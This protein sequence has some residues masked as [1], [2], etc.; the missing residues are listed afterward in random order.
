MRIA[1]PG[2]QLMVNV[3][4]GIATLTGEV[5]NLPRIA[6]TAVAH[7]P[8]PHA[9]VRPAPLSQVRRVAVSSR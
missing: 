7:A 8:V 3:P 4:P 6:A 2:A 5:T 1:S 9:K